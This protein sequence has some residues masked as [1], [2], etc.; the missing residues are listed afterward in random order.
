MFRNVLEEHNVP[1]LLKESIFSSL[2]KKED[3]VSKTFELF[4]TAKLT[5]SFLRDNFH[6]VP[7]TTIKLGSGSFQY[8]SVKET[9]KKVRADKTFQQLKKRN[10]SDNLCPDGEGFLLEDIDDGLLFKEN[11]FFRKNPDAMRKEKLL[12]EIFRHIIVCSH[13]QDNF[14]KLQK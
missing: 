1:D 10:P 7:P 9:L 4:R 14:R 13:L 2:L 5:E 11:K 6:Y 8:I 3:L 12:S